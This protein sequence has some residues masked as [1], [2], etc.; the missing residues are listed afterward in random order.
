MEERRGAYWVL[1]EG[2]LKDR[3]HLEDEGV[4]R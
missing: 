1:V 2:D 4:T 3:E